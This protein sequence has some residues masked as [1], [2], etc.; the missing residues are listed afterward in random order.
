LITLASDFRAR[1]RGP[2][3]STAEQIKARKPLS[4]G[5]QSWLGRSLTEG[6]AVE[7]TAAMGFNAQ[8]IVIIP[9]LDMVVIFNASLESVQMIAPEI[10]LLDKYVLPV[11]LRH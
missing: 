5:F 3:S 7:W 1:H 8:K 11:I 10:E 4:Y 6:R 2:A 9:E